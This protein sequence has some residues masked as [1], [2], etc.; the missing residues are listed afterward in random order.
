MVIRKASFVLGMAVTMLTALLAPPAWA[1]VHGGGGGH[2]GGGTPPPG[3]SS[4][5]AFVKAYS[6]LAGTRQVGVTAEDVQQTS[7]LGYVGIATTASSSQSGA[8][9]SWL[10]KTS[11]TGSPQWQRQVGC[12][13]GA[14][15]DYSIG[16]SIVQTADGGYVLGGGTIGCGSGSD[17]P[18]LGGIQC[19]LV[20]KVSSTGSVDWARVY[21]A[22]VNGSSITKIRQ[23]SDG[24]LIA[25]GTITDANHDVGGLVLKLDSQGMVQWQRQLGPA[26][27]DDVL[28]NDVQQS[29]DGGYVVAGYLAPHNTFA[30]AFVAKLDSSGNVAWQ[31]S[32]NSF[33]STGTPTTE[34]M[35]LSIIQT[36]DGGYL[37]AGHWV[38]TALSGTCCAGALLLKLD[39]SG[40]LQWQNA[41]SGGLY[42]FSNGF[43]ETCANL[44]A[45][46][47]T[48][49]QTSDG[50]YVLTGDETLKLTDSVP[51]EPWIAK[52]DT[53]GNLLWQHLY[54]QT[55]PASGRP[56]GENF[57][58]SVTTTDGGFYAGGFTENVNNGDAEF[59]AVK[60]DSSGLAGSTCGDTHPGTT[61]NSVNPAL[62]AKVPNV[63]VSSVTATVSSSPATTSATSVSTQTD[64]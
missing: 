10:L 6:N 62:T 17:C 7:D 39:S 5:A 22:G 36:S 61:L 16:V 34:T 25:A 19:A 4:S 40:A 37:A 1:A 32:F 38:S 31:Q 63:P 28:L 60:T 29:S 2:G 42:C 50:G 58:S 20:E 52:V 14:P 59:Y 55:N 45:V 11:A 26:G 41:L 44:G 24:G 49:H 57:S 46:A 48:A 33:D 53:S 8:T 9:V 54:Y 64:C 13:S 47:Y 21:N 12:L 15:G 43:S 51:L 30:S 23:A 35:G 3:P 27:T 56:L 18:E